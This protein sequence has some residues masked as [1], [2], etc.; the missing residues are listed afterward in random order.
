MGA[1]CQESR[2]SHLAN[3]STDPLIALA[4][5]HR[6]FRTLLHR[7]GNDPTSMALYSGRTLADDG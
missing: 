4:S 7:F 3:P 1:L 6:Q 2:L 5:P